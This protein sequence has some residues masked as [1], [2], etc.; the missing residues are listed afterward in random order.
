MY[1]HVAMW[2]LTYRLQ[3]PSIFLQETPNSA[4]LLSII[5]LYILNQ[6]LN[7]WILGRLNYL[8]IFC[9]CSEKL[10]IGDISQSRR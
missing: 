3:K 8:D 4:F 7:S 5:N 2:E 9:S 1:V 6:N 10:T